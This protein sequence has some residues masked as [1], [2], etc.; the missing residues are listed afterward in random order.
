MLE[1]VQCPGD[2]AVAVV[3]TDVVH[4]LVVDPV[5]LVNCFVPL[6]C[7]AGQVSNVDLEVPGGRSKGHDRERARSVG[8]DGVGPTKIVG[9]AHAIGNAQ[10][11][12]KGQDRRDRVEWRPQNAK[13]QVQ[14]VVIA[15]SVVVVARRRRFKIIRHGFGDGVRLIV[16]VPAAVASK[17]SVLGLGLQFAVGRCFAGLEVSSIAFGPRV[18]L[19]VLAGQGVVVSFVRRILLF[20]AHSPVQMHIASTYYM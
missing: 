12:N 7:P 20:H 16:V 15:A 13:G 3:A 2:V 8:L 4:P 5:G 11:P 17:L 19:S 18:C 6:A 9:P 10:M 1:D 14:F